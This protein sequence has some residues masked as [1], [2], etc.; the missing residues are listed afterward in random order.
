M[1]ISTKSTA[2]LI[3]EL[4]TTSNKCWHAQ[5]R[6]MD[7]SLSDSIRLTAAETAQTTN[8]RRCELMAEID[9]RLGER[10]VLPKTYA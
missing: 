8:A 9:R 1:N 5:D 3:D 7:K 4:I 10:S 6:I 2:T